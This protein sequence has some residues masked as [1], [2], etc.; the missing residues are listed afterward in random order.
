MNQKARNLHLQLP[1][2]PVIGTSVTVYDLVDS[3]NDLAFHQLEQGAP[4]GL[5]V[6]ADRQTAGRGRFSRKWFSAPGED[7][8]MTVGIRPPRDLVERLAP[9]AGL[10]MALTVDEIAGVRSTIKWP[11]DVRVDGLKIA[12]VLIETRVIGDETLAVRVDLEL[13]EVG[14]S[15]SIDGEIKLG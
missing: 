9:M 8:M 4:G 14:L 15:L 1:A 11:N 3:T 10:A 13:G 6:V 7:V 12:G 5:V 2:Q